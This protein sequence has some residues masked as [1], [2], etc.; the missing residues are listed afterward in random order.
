LPLLK[1]PADS[2]VLLPLLLV[3]T[4]LLSVL[5]VATG[6]DVRNLVTLRYHLLLALAPV[7]LTALAFLDGPRAD[8]GGTRPY[9]AAV[10]AGVVLWAAAMA[11]S[12]LR[13]LHEYRTGP[14]PSAYR[15]LADDLVAHG[16]RYGW[17]S[18]WVSYHVDF[19]SQERVQLSPTSA[20]RISE[21]AR[22]AMK[23]GRGATIVGSEPCDGG[24]AG[25]Q[26]AVWW[27]CRGT[28][29]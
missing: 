2:R 20:I 11:A 10:T 16:D 25:R 19:L 22:Q 6:C 24:S 21:Y 13:L 27:V 7:G 23:A 5:G 26:V 3:C 17:A 12:H 9:V 4:G 8:T 1:P 29:Q 28:G 15:L 14:P 18:Y